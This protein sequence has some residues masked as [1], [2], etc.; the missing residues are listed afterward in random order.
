[1]RLIYFKYIKIRIHYLLFFYV[2]IALLLL[3]FN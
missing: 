2:I 1:M 3:L